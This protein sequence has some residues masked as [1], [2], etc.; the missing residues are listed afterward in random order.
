[1][2]PDP[3]T[4]HANFIGIP[5]AHLDV[6]DEQPYNT[7]EFQGIV[8]SLLYCSTS[9]RPDIARAMSIVCSKASAPTYGDWRA[10]LRILQYLRSTCDV[11]IQ[12]TTPPARDSSGVVLSAYADSSLAPD[13]Q[14]GDGYS[15]TGY[16]LYLCGGPILWHSAKQTAVAKSTGESE[17]RALSA[18]TSDVVWLRGLLSELGFPQSLPTLVYEDNQGTLGMANADLLTRRTRGIVL[19]CCY[20]RDAIRRGVIRPYFCQSVHMLA[21]GLTKILGRVLFTQ[22]LLPLLGYEVHPVVVSPYVWSGQK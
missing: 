4:D 6:T 11:G 10:A 17:F 21:D 12:F 22:H 14:Q 18:C 2:D 7:Q 19:E 8:G 15:V 20:V 1:M 3:V 13:W 5:C 16:V 9:T